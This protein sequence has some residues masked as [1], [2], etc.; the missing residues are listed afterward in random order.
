MRP[1]CSRQSPLIYNHNEENQEDQ[2]TCG[3]SVLAIYEEFH[4]IG[5]ITS[6]KSEKS[7]YVTINF[8]QCT[9]IKLQRF[10]WP[11]RK[12]ELPI[13]KSDIICCIDDPVPSSKRVFSANLPEGLNLGI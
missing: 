2:L 6:E 5:K 12:D 8:M 11:Q 7:D 13:A 9:N 1:S 3:K 4:Y 10:K